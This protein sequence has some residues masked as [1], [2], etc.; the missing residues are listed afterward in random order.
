MDYRPHKDRHR[1]DWS[2][3]HSE[4]RIRTVVI[5][6]VLLVVPISLVALFYPALPIIHVP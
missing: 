3:M 6:I 2:D 1:E 5:V 4:S